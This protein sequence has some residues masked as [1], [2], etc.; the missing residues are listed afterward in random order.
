MCVGGGR[1]VCSVPG[2]VSTCVWVEGGRCAV[3][4]EVCGW[5]GE[6]VQCAWRGEYVCVGGRRKVC[7]VPGGVSMCVWVE[8][9]RCP[10]CLEG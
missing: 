9:G 4:L 3:C 6:G 5:R 8:G 7:S 10:V 2:G 1:K